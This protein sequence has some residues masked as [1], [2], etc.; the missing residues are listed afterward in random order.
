MEQQLPLEAKGVQCT[1][2]FEAGGASIGL[3]VYGPFTNREPWWERLENNGMNS[4]SVLEHTESPA[5]TDSRLPA[6]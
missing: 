6:D 3:W 4:H 2:L 5:S 1:S